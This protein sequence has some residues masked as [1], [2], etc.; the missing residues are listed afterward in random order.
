[1]EIIVRFQPV[2]TDLRMVIASMKT[3]TNLE[4]IS[5]QAVSI[6]KRSRKILKN[7]EIPDI[8]RLEGLYQVAAN[9]LAD[10]ITAYSDNNAELALK[11]IEQQDHLKKKT[12]RKYHVFSPANWNPKRVTTVITLTWSL[13]ATGWIV[14]ADWPLTLPRM[15]SMKSHPPIFAMAESCPQS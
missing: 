15:S 11:V 13:F 5:D 1:L 6:A 4:R 3:A 2:A 7:D 14:W 12:T 8:R 10:A 9:M